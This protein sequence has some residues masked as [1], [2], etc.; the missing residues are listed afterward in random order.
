MASGGMVAEA[1]EALL[2]AGVPDA[3]AAFVEACRLE[4]GLL[5]PASLHHTSGR[6]AHTSATGGG[7]GA[8]QL[9]S[10]QST[11]AAAVGRR[12]LAT[13]PAVLTAGVGGRGGAGGGGFL[14][15]DDD[16]LACDS[17]TATQAFGGSSGRGAMAGTPTRGS[18]ALP[19]YAD[20]R[21]GG[22]CSRPHAVVALLAAASGAGGGASLIV[23]AV[24][25]RY[26]QYVIDVLTG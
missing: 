19:S 21:A 2:E 26:E 8:T 5:P 23:A 15:L 16:A 10:H 24:E 14:G 22:D 3:A 11:A 18:D 6:G 17:P 13:G 9:L 25:R 1:A 4:G 20:V 12:K 7:G